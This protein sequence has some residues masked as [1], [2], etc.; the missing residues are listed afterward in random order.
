MISNK[1][2]IL[3]Y[4]KGCSYVAVILH[5]RVP[6][7]YT[8]YTYAANDE[9]RLW[10]LLSKRGRRGNL[11]VPQEVVIDGEAG[12]VHEHAGVEVQ[13]GLG[14]HFRRPLDPAGALLAVA[15]LVLGGV[16]PGLLA[17]AV[18]HGVQVAVR[19]VE[20]VVDVLEHLDVSVQVDHLVVLHELQLINHSQ[21][22]S[23]ITSLNSCWNLHGIRNPLLFFFGW[24]HGKSIQGKENR[25]CN[26]HLL[27]SKKRYSYPE[28]IYFSVLY[29]PNPGTH[30]LW[31]STSTL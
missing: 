31:S 24:G 25:P 18:L 8:Q 7:L 21:T 22:R 28:N 9:N 5:Y 12:L 16:G 30:K 6:S 2:L 15:D 1:F 10:Y 27:A 11:E 19:H 23:Y 26:F 14:S 29:I 20:E 3:A 17:E 13:R 4:G